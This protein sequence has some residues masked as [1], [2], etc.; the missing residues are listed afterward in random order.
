[1]TDSVERPPE[2]NSTKK[3]K[4]RMDKYGRKL[5]KERTEYSDLP[6]WVRTA[7]AMKY[8]LGMTWKQVADKVGKS[9]STVDA[10]KRSPAFK[11]WREELKDAAQDPKTMAEYALKA[12]AMGVTM[13]YLAA[14]QKA[15]DAS[16][17]E[18]TGKMA[19]DLLDRVGV[20]KKKDTQSSQPSLHIT[21]AGGA[22]DAPA[23]EADYEIV[24]DEEPK[25]LNE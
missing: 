9:P 25:L 2:E 14:F 18:A 17:Y 13:E 19:R 10:Y 7:A 12:S 24:E 20:T 23:I 1:M 4:A 16:D 15:I 11:R 5:P 3:I 22:A 6:T 8:V 21:I